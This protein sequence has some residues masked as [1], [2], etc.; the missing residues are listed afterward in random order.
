MQRNVNFAVWGSEVSIHP[1]LAKYVDILHRFQNQ[2]EV[3]L[4][5][6][7]KFESSREPEEKICKDVKESAETDARAI[8][9]ELSDYGV[10]NKT[11]SDFIPKETFESIFSA[12]QSGKASD[13]RK[14]SL[15]YQDTLD[16]LDYERDSSVTGLP[17]GILTSS[18]IGVGVYAL[19]QNAEIKKQQQK[20]NAD[21]VSNK[22]RL[23]EINENA[24]AGVKEEHRKLFL[25]NLRKTVLELYDRLLTKYIVE[26][27]NCGQFDL[28]CMNGISVERSTE[29]LQ[30][31][32]IV[33]DKQGL[34]R[35]SLLLCPFNPLVYA[36][37]GIA[38]MMDSTLCE[39][40]LFLH[41]SDDVIQIIEMMSGL[42]DAINLKASEIIKQFKTPCKAISSLQNKPQ[43]EILYHYFPRVKRNAVSRFRVFSVFLHVEKSTM[44][45]Y[46]ERFV[47]LYGDQIQKYRETGDCLQFVQACTLD[48]EDAEFLV[49]DFE[50]YNLVPEISEIIGFSVNS[51]YSDV[52]QFMS[53]SIKPFL[54]QAVTYANEKAIRL[55]EDRVKRENEKK[56]QEKKIKQK[57]KL[58]DRT[59]KG[60]IIAF[61]VCIIWEIIVV[62]AVD[63]VEYGTFGSYVFIASGLISG[64]YALG[65][66]ITMLIK[67][68]IDKYLW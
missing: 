26:L 57:Q 11:V 44:Q 10:L 6:I 45:A 22:I 40:V 18:V 28:T 51:R 63:G 50:E 25:S 60:F 42:K 14:I 56:E 33:S 67:S 36:K 43:K 32:E 58:I 31:I 64:I 1:D 52:L 9:A 46:L 49:S 30:N 12:F 8:I 66:I 54:D 38:G 55:E 35:Q 19:Q 65:F 17:F 61:V 7:Q 15:T 23:E 53:D 5:K 4:A 34:F 24:K 2:K 27:S 29:L 3:L 20:A 41:L 48:Q 37:A 13:L 59:K 68:L 16:F 62:F 39:L 47:S 21:Y